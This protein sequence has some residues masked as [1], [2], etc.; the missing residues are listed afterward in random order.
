[1]C[2]SKASSRTGSA[3]ITVDQSGENMIVISPGANAKLRPD[4]L[5]SG[6]S[7]LE[8]CQALL[9]QFETPSEV[10]VEAASVA[11]R[12][13]I[14]VV[15][16]PSPM[17]LD[18]PWHLIQT[19]YLIVNEGEAVEVLGFLPLSEDP[20]TLRQRLHELRVEH[21]VV[22]RGAS[23]T[24]VFSRTGE[25]FEVE[26]LPVLPVDTVGAGDAFA[27][28]FTA[29]IAAGEDLEDSIRAAN[30]AGALTTLGP[31]AQDPIP[32][33]EKVDQ[34]LDHLSAAP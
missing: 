6:R 2:V 3:F 30:C 26:T 10:L 27:G 5:K 11:N 33:R 8:S 4:D 17:Q 22:T 29:R 7:L 24:L 31:G 12:E 1:S 19:D 13:N 32:D 9:G 25:S 34:H 28:C 21:L 14:P 16:N 20:S 23:P 18:F 15:I